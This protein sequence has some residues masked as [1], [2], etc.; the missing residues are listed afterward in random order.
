MQAIGWNPALHLNINNIGP[1]MKELG[2][3][4]KR[5]DNERG[6][7]V[8]RYNEMEKCEQKWAKAALAKDEDESDDENNA[9]N[10]TIF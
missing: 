8:C 1:A 7:L 6:Y 4:R 3:I 2:F 5:V 9:T 10:A